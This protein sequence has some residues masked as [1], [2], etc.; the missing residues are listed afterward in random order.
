M[1]IDMAEGYTPPEFALRRLVNY[2]WIPF[3][4]LDKL[5]LFLKELEE[6]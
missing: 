6:K 3:F 4:Q 5:K 1:F 2:G